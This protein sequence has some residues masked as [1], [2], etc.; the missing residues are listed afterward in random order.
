MLDVKNR[1]GKRVKRL[2]FCPCHAEELLRQ[3]QAIIGCITG[4]GG[5]EDPV[6]AH[7]ESFESELCGLTI[8]IL[9]FSFD[10][11]AGRPILQ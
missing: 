10:S 4:A 8:R 2:A 11:F 3:M 5:L 7:R 6:H 1:I 9:H